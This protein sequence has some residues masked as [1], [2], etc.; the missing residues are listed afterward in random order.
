MTTFTDNTNTEL[1]DF[2]FFVLGN[3]LDL[4]N[5]RQVDKKIIDD[6]L[7]MHPKVKYF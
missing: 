5:E 7:E 6:F 1:A 3:K 4:S 2:P